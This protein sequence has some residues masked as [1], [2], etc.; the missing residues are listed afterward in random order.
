VFAGMVKGDGTAGIANAAET[1]ND[2]GYDDVAWFTSGP[3][4]GN[5]TASPGFTVDDCQNDA[6]P[7]AA[8]TGSGKGAFTGGNWLTGMWLDWADD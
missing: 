4:T 7:T 1:D 8:V 5:G 2:S 6:G 3:N